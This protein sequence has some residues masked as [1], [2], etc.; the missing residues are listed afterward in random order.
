MARGLDIPDIQLVINYNCPTFKED[1]VHRI[2]RTGRAGNKGVAVTFI[3]KDDDQ[4]VKE[5]I[6]ILEISNQEIP[7]WLNNLYLNFRE[8]VRR[9]EA[10]VIK[11][12][13][14]QGR[15]YKFDAEEQI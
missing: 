15:G 1:Y 3:T 5:L 14:F 7:D 9:G 12:K 8:K 6:E 2:G 11:N 4:Y 13:N 10:K